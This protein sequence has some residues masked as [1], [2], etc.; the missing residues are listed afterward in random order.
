MDVDRD[1]V[2]A[3]SQA[4]NCQTSFDRVE[5]C[6]G[7][8][9]HND[10]DGSVVDHDA[11]HEKGIGDKTQTLA[12]AVPNRTVTKPFRKRERA[13]TIASSSNSTRQPPMK[14][15]KSLFDFV[16]VKSDISVD[17][18]AARAIAEAE[19]QLTTVISEAD[20]PILPTPS[21]ASGY[22][23]SGGAIG[24][25]KSSIAAQVLKE[26]LRTGALGDKELRRRQERFVAKVKAI[27]VDAVTKFEGATTRV[28][29]STCNISIAM[30][31]PFTIG[32]FNRHILNCKVVKPATLKS[33]FVPSKLSGDNEA[34]TQEEAK[35]ILT[36]VQRPCR[37][38]TA[39]V[40][41]RIDQYLARHR[42]QKC[43]RPFP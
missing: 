32:H 2:R 10:L 41:K 9:V 12:P 20:S 38:L 25:G 1:H 17:A 11:Q 43:R 22:T 40:D 4:I 28:T 39:A 23:S 3:A 35:V 6:T 7:A 21:R 29:H 13:L 27:D 24:V 15:Q 36:P 5:G 34:L 14:R 33:F 16:N 31:E 30:K 42:F 19:A 37:G 8:P 26:K 18:V